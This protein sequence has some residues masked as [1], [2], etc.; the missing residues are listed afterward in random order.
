MIHCQCGT[1]TSEYH[2]G[3]GEGGGL[4]ISYSMRPSGYNGDSPATGQKQTGRVP[5]SNSHIELSATECIGYK[6]FKR[7]YDKSLRKKDL[8][9]Q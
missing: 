1:E 6:R 7:Q 5:F 4:T 9:N 2:Q 3:S 8:W